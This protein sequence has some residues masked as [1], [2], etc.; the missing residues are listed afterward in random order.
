MVPPARSPRATLLREIVNMD[1][2]D[3]DAWYYLGP[4][5]DS[6]IFGSARPA[7]E[8]LIKLRPDSADAHAKLAFALA[9]G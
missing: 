4:A 6:E 8:Q 9:I 5:F 2:D 3:A 7:F 1:P